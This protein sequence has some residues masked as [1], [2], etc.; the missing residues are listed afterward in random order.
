MKNKP[1]FSILTANEQE[2][3]VRLLEAIVDV[4]RPQNIREEKKVRKK[5]SP[6]IKKEDDKLT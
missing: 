3:A 2:K 1:L 5:V 4:L 6:S